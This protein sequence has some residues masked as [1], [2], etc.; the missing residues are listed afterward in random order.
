MGKKEVKISLFTDDK[1]VYINGPTNS[2]MTPLQ[3]INTL[4]K[5]RRYKLTHKPSIPLLYANDR[6]T[7]KETRGKILVT[8]AKK[9][10]KKKKKNL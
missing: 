5:V 1:I 3:L 6:W 9:K 7:E 8:I 10:K 4:S 2:T